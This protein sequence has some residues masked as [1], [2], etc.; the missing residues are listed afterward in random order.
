MVKGSRSLRCVVASCSILIATTGVAWAQASV[1]ISQ[2]VAD[3]GG[4]TAYF[5]VRE[6]DRPVATVT[7]AA[8]TGVLEGRS[9]TITSLAKVDA[10]NTPVL[11]VILVDV[12]KSIGEDALN[13]FRNA[14][15]RLID[16][17][18][19]ADRVTLFSVGETVTPEL[20]ASADKDVLKQ[21]LKRLRATSSKTLLYDAIGRGIERAQLTRSGEPTRRAI[22][23]FSDGQDDGSGLTI[24]NLRQ[25]LD[26]ARVP[27]FVTGYRPAS[28]NAAGQAALRT[29]QNLA[30]TSGGIYA[31][32]APTEIQ[33]VH[34]RV[35]TAVR[36][37]WVA[38]F[39]C[40]RC[41]F[42]GLSHTLLVT[43]ASGGYT[44]NDSLKVTLPFVIVDVP[45]WRQWPFLAT[46]GGVGLVLMG[47]VLWLALRPRRSGVTIDGSAPAVKRRH[48]V[49]V[50][51]DPANRLNAPSAPV[52]PM[53]PPRAAP[54]PP[55]TIVNP[56]IR[57]TPANPAPSPAKPVTPA[58]SGIG[59]GSVSL[60]VV[61]GGRPGAS[62]ALPVDSGRSVAAGSSR[63]CQVVLEDDPSVQE[64][65]FEIVSEG[66][67]MFVIDRAG[68][69][70]RVNGVRI[71]GRSRLETGDL[72]GAGSTELRIRIGAS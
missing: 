3:S 63:Q 31:D 30:T 8:I 44:P 6:G 54:P 16:T 14:A 28:L 36:E 66:G 52:P 39:T 23:I 33:R 11:Y 24:D 48:N 4:V 58:V 72:I 49:T 35:Q 60:T 53:P 65:H 37:G 5:T 10:A 43:Y 20:Q 64:R 1:S 12:S 29:L 59:R 50:R 47:V 68:G 71:D 46:T 57:A 34:E 62:F 22:V 41:P 70:T 32:A 42:D 61:T 45:W 55:V 18:Q 26:S 51:V 9:L 40:G 7:Q 2:A 19:P 13:L 25:R 56:P 15:T 38:K 17:M 27:I 69:R 67:Q 21:T